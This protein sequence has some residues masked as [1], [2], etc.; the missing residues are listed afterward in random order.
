MK[1]GAAHASV[2]ALP[3]AAPR[4]LQ[5]GRVSLRSVAR[6]WEQLALYLPVFMM[7]LLAL[8]TYWLVKNTPGAPTPAA[9]AVASQS[10]DYFMRR[11]NVKT[12]DASGRLKTE[13]AGTE[14]RHFPHSQILEID[15]VR[16]RSLGPDGRLTTA[17]AR[18]GLSN[19]AGNEIQLI[20]DAVVVREPIQLADG[21]VLPRLEF[22]GEFLHVFTDIEQV[23]SHLPV[24]LRRG[25]DEFK[26]D[27]FNY[28][29]LDQVANLQGRVKALMLPR[30]GK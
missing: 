14:A 3:L 22:R 25:G 1:S 27:T 9:P 15:D 11:A 19:D 24:T 26:G 10:A 18:R 20:G 2:P 29:N 7:G 4:S 12:F 30:Q 13:I 23:R 6:A 21:R 28:D 16:V 8:G 17:S 5:A